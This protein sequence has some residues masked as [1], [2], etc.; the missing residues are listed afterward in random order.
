MAKQANTNP[1]GARTD[2]VDY[3]AV[4]LA[5]KKANISNYSTN[6]TNTA[7]PGVSLKRPKADSNPA[8]NP[9][10]KGQPAKVP[11]ASLNRKAR[12]K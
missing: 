12:T 8:K 5:R 3:G 10:G 4:R 2:K 9:M 6:G 1:M 11:N 7:A